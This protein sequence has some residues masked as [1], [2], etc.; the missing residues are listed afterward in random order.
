MG[1]VRSAALLVGATLLGCTP[2][3]SGPRPTLDPNLVPALMEWKVGL[4]EKDGPSALIE[5]VLPT[6][7]RGIP[8][9]RIVHRD[10]DPTADGSFNSYDLYD[11]A[12]DTLH[13]LR[14]VMNREGLFLS[15]TFDSDR[16]T[17]EKREGDAH[18]RSELPV[19]DPKPEGPGMT[20]FVAA[21]PLQAGFSTSFQIVDRWATDDS[22]RV[23]WVDLQ[24]TRERVIPT[25]WGRCPSLDLIVVPRDGSFR[26]RQSVLASAPHYPLTTEY[27][28]GELV[29]A[30]EVTRMII[31]GQ[32]PCAP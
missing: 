12:M 16:V 4:G 7:H 27:R 8:V 17:I 32:S 6:S 22:T 18:A 29:L 10:P 15:L 1:L 14:S 19:R 24:V 21:L 9:W 3:S 30:S 13:P 11:V 20:A 31:A 26:I 23:K 5:T 2:R 28:R 25:A